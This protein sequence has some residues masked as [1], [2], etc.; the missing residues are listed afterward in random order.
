MGP[1]R[2]AGRNK[3]C[4]RP[5]SQPSLTKLDR[6][7]GETRTYRATARLKDVTPLVTN[8]LQVKISCAREFH[9]AMCYPWK[10]WQGM[11]LI[12]LARVCGNS[13]KKS[14]F[15]ALLLAWTITQAAAVSE[16]YE[17]NPKN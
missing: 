3:D 13:M 10:N 2:L 5:T 8:C 9:G 14:I 12:P 1:D 17:I 11:C 16:T 4:H 7:V 6:N 15:P